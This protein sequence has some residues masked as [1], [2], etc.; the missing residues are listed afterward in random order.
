MILV[1]VVSAWRY[2]IWNIKRNIYRKE[3]TSIRT[4]DAEAS[5]IGLP[6]LDELV[7]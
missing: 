6:T 3:F 1:C 5:A 4:G 2:F 7:S